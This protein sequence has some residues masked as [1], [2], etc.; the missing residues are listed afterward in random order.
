VIFW[1]K[2]ALQ[3]IQLEPDVFDRT[4]LKKPELLLNDSEVTNE[5]NE[6][7][8]NNEDYELIQEEDYEFVD[9]D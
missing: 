3:R 7:D 6:D 5:S 2:D 8:I 4:I 9:I 1:I